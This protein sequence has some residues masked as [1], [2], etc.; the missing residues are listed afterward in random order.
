MRKPTTLLEN[1][2]AMAQH[3]HLGIIQTNL[4]VNVII[5]CF[6]VECEKKSVNT[7]ICSLGSIKKNLTSVMYEFSDSK[8]IPTLYS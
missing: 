1:S 7:S 4:S 2:T 6:L 5:Y 8:T 3:N